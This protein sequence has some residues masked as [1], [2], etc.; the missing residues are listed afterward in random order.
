MKNLVLAVAFIL[1]QVAAFANTGNPTEDK[2]RL[3]VKTSE[4]S[5]VKLRLINLANEKTTLRLVNENYDKVYQKEITSPTGFA[6][7]LDLSKLASGDYLLTV[8]RANKSYSQELIINE[9]GKVIIGEMEEVSKP[10][11]T[12]KEENFI[13]TSPNTIIKTVSILNKEGNV[14]YEKQY[15]EKENKAKRVIYD[16]KKA[17]TGTYTVKILTANNIY[18]EEIKV[19]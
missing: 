17:K 14:L 12:Q 7:T 3:F 1:V 18:Y 5:S 9:F 2:S 6:M 11:L 15:A 13:I 19:K 4:A 8:T 16:L 10:I